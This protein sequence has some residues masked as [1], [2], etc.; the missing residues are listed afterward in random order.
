MLQGTR[1]NWLHG[2]HAGC[3]GVAHYDGWLGS[4][5]NRVAAV[6]SWVICCGNN[7]RLMLDGRVVA[8][9]GRAEGDQDMVINAGKFRDQKSDWAVAEVI[10]WRRQLSDEEMKEVRA[11][12]GGAHA[13]ARSLA[14]SLAHPLASTAQHSTAQEGALTTCSRS[15]GTPWLTGR[16]HEARSWNLTHARSKTRTTHAPLPPRARNRPAHTCASCSSTARAHRRHRRRH[17]SGH[18]LGCSAGAAPRRQRAG[19]LTVVEEP[20]VDA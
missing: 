18:G 17:A 7:R 19:P 1:S 14:R 4:G 2:H 13:H 11:P 20:T 9:K 12:R 10:T 16:T 15:S 8:E 3:A 6:D 5:L